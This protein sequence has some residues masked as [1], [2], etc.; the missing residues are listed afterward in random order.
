MEKLL[1]RYKK[2]PTNWACTVFPLSSF[3]VVLIGTNLEKCDMQFATAAFAPQYL[4]DKKVE[5]V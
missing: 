4:R 3:T 5:T 2:I 1:K